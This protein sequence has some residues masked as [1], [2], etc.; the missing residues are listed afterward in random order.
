MTIVRCW[1]IVML[2]CAGLLADTCAAQQITRMSDRQEIGFAPMMQELAGARVI[3]VGE[4]HDDK[5]H[6]DLQLEVLRMLHA[7][8]VPLAIGLEMFVTESQRELDKWSDGTMP[9]QSFRQVYS[10]NWSVEWRMYR[11]IF[12]FAREHRIPLIALNVPQPIMA[13]VA[14]HGFASLS[15]EDKK[16]LPPDVTCVLNTPY[17]EFLRKVYSEHIA[18]HGSFTYFCEAQTLRNNEMAWN[19]ARYARAHPG[20]T[21]V[22][23]AGAWHVVKNGIPEQLARYGEL[24]CKVI[25]PELPVFPIEA[26]SFLD[27]DYFFR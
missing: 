27:A 5:K 19:I 7:R 9:E 20:Q 15:R 22:T 18:N 13:K 12:L 10:R 11:D 25:L 17:T 8:G 6:H 21:V 24:P 1:A 2:I 4:T 3:L 14:A 16:E 26:A 23:L